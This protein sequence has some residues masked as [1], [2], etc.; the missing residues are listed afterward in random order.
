[1]TCGSLPP[2]AR[3]R[4]AEGGWSAKP[5][6]LT[7]RVLSAGFARLSAIPGAIVRGFLALV[8]THPSHC[9]RID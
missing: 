3:Q 7:F 6:L 2:A 4:K 9:D 5:P 8:R 1:M